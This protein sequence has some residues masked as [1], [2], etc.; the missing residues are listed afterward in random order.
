[1]HKHLIKFVWIQFQPYI[2][3]QTHKNEQAYKWSGSYSDKILLDWSLPCNVEVKLMHKWWSWISKHSL[4]EEM[5][6][7]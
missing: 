4:A 5:D 3:R 1:M 2:T 6:L 7:I